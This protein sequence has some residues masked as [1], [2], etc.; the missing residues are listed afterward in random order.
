LGSG[1]EAE[2]R[3]SEPCSKPLPRALVDEL[4]MQ[5]RDIL[6]V[7][8]AADP[9][10]AFDLA[11]FL[12][13]DRML[14]YSSGS[15]GSSLLAIPPSNPVF[16]FEAPE[17][18]ATL[19]RSKAADALDR[20]WTGGATME[21]RFDA[22]RALPEPSRAAWLGHVV[23][24]TLEASAGGEGERACSF[25]DHLGRLLGIDVASWWRPTGANFFDRLPKAV[26]LAALEEI[27]GSAFAGRYAKEKKA[28]LCEAAQRICAG[29]FIAEVDVKARALAWLPEAMRFGAGTEEEV[30][31]G[32]PPWEEELLAPDGDTSVPDCQEAGP[33]AVGDEPSELDEAA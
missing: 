5:R 31:D 3:E 10:L 28:P 29:E 13:V 21:E 26:T 30:A 7:H 23:A 1:I 14:V 18:A 11:I 20:S 27:G 6:A 2:E 15:S 4:A 9:Q 32:T 25:H 33:E 16:G 8:V 12:M 22:F 19:A 17:A 24:G